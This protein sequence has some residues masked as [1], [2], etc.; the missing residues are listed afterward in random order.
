MLYQKF[1]SGVLVLVKKI[2]VGTKQKEMFLERVLIGCK[3]LN[4][5][6]RGTS[7]KSLRPSLTKLN[8]CQTQILTKRVKIIL[9]RAS[10][11]PFPSVVEQNVILTRNLPLSFHLYAITGCMKFLF[12]D[13]KLK[14]KKPKNHLKFTI[15]EN[16]ITLNE[17]DYYRKKYRHAS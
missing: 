3:T 12:E 10:E 2:Y 14:D 7:K 5:N 16:F 11:E 17:N 8:K 13:N 15:L 4:F 6:L 1:N 9:L